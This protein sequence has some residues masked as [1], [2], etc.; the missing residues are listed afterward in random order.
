MSGLSTPANIIPTPIPHVVLH[1]P[2]EAYCLTGL[3]PSDIPQIPPMVN[4]PEVSPTLGFHGVVD[5]TIAQGFY[6]DLKWTARDW[7]FFGPYRPLTA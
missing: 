5:E 6:D 7:P 3:L 2:F 4:H 1:Q